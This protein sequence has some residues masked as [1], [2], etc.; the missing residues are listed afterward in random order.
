[1]DSSTRAESG[2]FRYGLAVAGLLTL[3]CTNVGVM[4]SSEIER[5]SLKLKTQLTIVS[6]P[7]IL[8]FEEELDE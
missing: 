1:M 6:L 7:K 8:F 5:C 4:V 3:F 2:L